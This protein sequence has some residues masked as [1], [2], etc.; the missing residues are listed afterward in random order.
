MGVKNQSLESIELLFQRSGGVAR[1]SDFVAAGFSKP[2]IAAYVRAGML[3]R[4]AHGIYMRKGAVVDE[5]Y[6]LQLRSPRIVFSHETA[7][8]L[9]GLTDRHPFELTVTLATGSPLSLSLRDSCRCHYVKPNLLEDGLAPMKNE[10]GHEVRCYGP[11]RTLCDMLRNERSVGV[12]ELTEGLRRYARWK[13]RNLPE[14]MRLAALF[15]IERDMAKC[16]GV[17]V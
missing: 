8:W 5:Q 16:M 4:V 12:E 11:E 9:N 6:I 14:L 1:A 15:G 2:T 3:E 17:L 13:D 10:F 7:L